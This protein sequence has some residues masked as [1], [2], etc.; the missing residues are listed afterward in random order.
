[1]SVPRVIR[2]LVE[3]LLESQYIVLG[4]WV[5]FAGVLFFGSVLN[6][7]LVSLAERQRE[8]ATF[9][10]LGYTRWQVGA[11]FMRESMLINTAGTLMGLP[12]GYGLAKLMVTPTNDIL[13]AVGQLAGL[14]QG[15]A[16]PR[17]LPWRGIVMGG[18]AAGLLQSLKVQE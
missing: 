15:T 6:A 12:V 8:V 13:H 1:M 17:C 5:V 10:A 18:H 7:S 14:D 4:V 3:A 11:M 16:L 9:M 2:K